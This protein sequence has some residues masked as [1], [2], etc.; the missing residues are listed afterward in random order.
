[1]AESQADEQRKEER[2][3]NTENH[4]CPPKAE[5]GCQYDTVLMAIIFSQ[6][7]SSMMPALLQQISTAPSLEMAAENT[8]GGQDG[9]KGGRVMSCYC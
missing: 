8:S 9:Q 3:V 1:M 2:C 4:S 7:L 5:R 6:I